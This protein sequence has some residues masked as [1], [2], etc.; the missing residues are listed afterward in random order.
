M[1]IKTG[2]KN[3]DTRKKIK[4][5]TILASATAAGKAA[6]TS[7]SNFFTKLT[8]Q[9]EADAP[10]RSCIIRNIVMTVIIIGVCI[11]LFDIIQHPQTASHNVDKYFFII[12]IPLVL[13]FAILFN[14]GKGETSSE[15]G[16]SAFFKITG[17]LLLLGVLVYYYSQMRGGGLNIP[18]LYQHYALIGLISIV[19]L[20]IF[21][22]VFSDYIARLPGWMGF[23]GQ[24]LFYIPCM[25]YDSWLYLFEQFRITPASIYVLIAL[26]ILLIII[27]VFLPKITSAITG[28]RDG[29]QLLVDP[30]FLNKGLQV[31]ATSDDL[32]VPQSNTQFINGV[33]SDQYRTNYCLSMWVYINTQNGSHIAYTKEAEILNYGYKDASG[34]QHVKPMMRYYGGIGDGTDSVVERNK[35]VFYFSKYPPTQQYDASG[36][37]F[38]DVSILTQRWNQIVFNYNRNNV[39]L[40]ING[41]LERSFLMTTLPQYNDLDQITIGDSNVNGIQGAICNVAYYN[42]PLS[43]Q[44]ITYSYNMLLNQDPPIGLGTSISSTPAPTSS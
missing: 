17:V 32:K 13:V 36:D 25:L 4:G 42:H 35:F 12:A 7:T 30:V 21:Y 10:W 37:T 28:L 38:Y 11:L 40:F 44:Q 33:N 18:S 14:L 39:D 6:Y 16:L 31:I 15:N 34:I 26:E 8:S 22:H 1:S 43:L 9:N 20:A 27:Y 19:G 24:L 23:I 29:K 3:G 41:R 2:G 5:G